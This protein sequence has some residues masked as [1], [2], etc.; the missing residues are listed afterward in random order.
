MLDAGAHYYRADF[1]VH[2]PRDTNW[3][4]AR[5]TSEEERRAYGAEF[6]AACRIKG[7]QAVAITDHHDFAI[8]PYI[9]Q[10]AADEVD[11]N[12]DPLPVADRLVV[13]PG[14]EL[15]LA[16]PCQAIL[17]LDADFPEE[18]LSSVLEALAIVETDPTAERL[19]PV[20]RLDHI[21]SFEELYSTL[22]ARPWLQGRYTVFPNVTDGGYKTLMRSGMHA[23]YKGMPCAGGYLDG[24]VEAKAKPSSGNRRIF[25]GLDAN[26][27]RKRLGLFQTSDS[28]SRD[29]KDLGK[30]SSWVKW[31][32]PT[33]EAL[34]QACLAQESRI[35]HVEPAL[36]NIFISSVHVSNS[37]FLGPFDL[38][39]NRQYNALIGGRGTG[40]STILDYIRWCIGDAPTGMSTEEGAPSADVRRQRLIAATLASVDGQ[41]EVAFVLNGIEHIVRR[42]G[43]S[44][45]MLL[46]IGDGGFGQ[47]NEGAVQALL[48]IHAYSQKQLSSVAVLPEELTRFITAPIRQSLQA[49][50]DAIGDTANRLRQNYAA[51]RRSRSVAGDARRAISS[52]KSLLD[53]AAYLRQSLAGLSEQDQKLLSERPAVDGSREAIAAWR[54]AA[55]GLAERA[56]ETLDD[57][58]RLVHQLPAPTV[59][60]SA[61]LLD[62]M[63]KA[64]KSVV[65]AADVIRSALRPAQA[66]VAAAVADGGDV[67]EALDGAE[68]IVGQ[69]D[70]D[71]EDVKNR[72]ASHEQ[73]LG[74][75]AEIERRR[76]A[77]ADQLVLLRQES[78]VLGDP[79]SVQ[80]ELRQRLTELYGERSELLREQCR[81]VTE[82]SDGLLKAE[83]VR[84]QGLAQVDERF[85]AL[86]SGSGI[87]STRF[88]AFFAALAAESAPLDTWES[89]LSELEQSILLDENVELTSELT[90]TLSRLG[91]PVADQ[92]RLRSRVTVDSW[93]D[94]ALTPIE[95]KPVFS[96]RTREQQYMEFAAASAGQQATALLRVLLAQTGM[97][98]LID[99]PEEDLDSQIIEDIVTWLWESKSRRQVIVASHNANLVVNGDAELVAVCD[100]RRAGD[101]SGG[102]IKLA[103]AI[104]VAQLRDEIT[105]V[106]EGGERAFKLRRDK[107]GF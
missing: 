57:V 36:P 37:S 77:V 4:G 34:R 8:F 61:E 54:R 80:R 102:R 81:V 22:D 46:K 3:E 7:L 41:V 23:K 27:G 51:L 71:Y 28:R 97:P 18:K 25:D 64:R 19:P 47:V 69:L 100:Y 89:I 2:T 14:L 65:D 12:G 86:A 105:H 88:E 78:D 98:L 68:A 99:Q 6:V 95:D 106:M 67:G 103:G 76:T 70:S 30:N 49:K 32:E 75:L 9:R 44:G 73:Q 104:D 35:S 58:D 90:P 82:Q 94:L 15:T 10:A 87:R 26:W 56:T 83:V 20:T 45:E 17:I 52:E 39:F 1:Q 29:F 101:Q 93:L 92:Q 42:S 5:A 43:K 62:A 63:A 40:K 16:V 84:G 59:D 13:F 74:Q 107:Y 53:Q 33:A 91:L 31:A 60:V 96:Y 72:S 55:A 50:D 21:Q 24:T 85:R 11:V 48:P 38:A 79:E 66:S